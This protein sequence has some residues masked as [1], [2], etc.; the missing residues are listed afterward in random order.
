M[1]KQRRFRIRRR[2][3]QIIIGL[4]A[5]SIVAILQ[6]FAAEPSRAELTT[7]AL[8]AGAYFA[9][10]GD[11]IERRATGER[12]RVAN[13]DTPET[14]DRARCVAE[15]QRGEMAKQRVRAMLSEA[16]SVEVESV[17][18]TDAYGRT[19]DYIAVD[20]RDLGTVLIAEHLA[21]PWRGRREPWCR[22]DGGLLL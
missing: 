14:A 18:R 1:S 13:I 9:I 8:S 3:A 10:D 6:I 17:G 5:V 16:I 22:A 7:Q 2:E 19:V 12:I 15:R 11:T 20:G 4:C 21:R